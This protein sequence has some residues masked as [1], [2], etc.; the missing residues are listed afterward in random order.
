MHVEE[1]K[2]LAGV[3]FFLIPGVEMI[4]KGKYFSHHLID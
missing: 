1:V 2:R 4:D 3:F